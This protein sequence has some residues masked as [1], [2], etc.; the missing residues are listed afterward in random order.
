MASPEFI[1]LAAL[2]VIA[3]TLLLVIPLLRKSSTP[4]TITAA[5]VIAVTPLSV[6]GLYLAFTSW[7]AQRAVPVAADQPPSVEQMV[8]GLEQRLRDQPNDLEGWMMLG[9]SYVVMGRYNEAVTAYQRARQ[10]SGDEQAEALTGYAEAL[11][12]ASNGRLA[13]EPAQLFERVLQMA[14]NDRKA[15]WYGGLAALEQDD[16]A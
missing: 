10:L 13:G 5:V 2:M 14:P 1:A 6:A 3:A 11:A 8:S 16:P 9:R 15:L 4:A 7:S 12:L